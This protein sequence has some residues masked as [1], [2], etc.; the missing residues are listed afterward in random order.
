M[1]KPEPAAVHEVD[2]KKDAHG[3]GRALATIAQ[4]LMTDCVSL[5]ISTPAA[6]SAFVHAVMRSYLGSGPQRIF[7][8]DDFSCCALV[9]EIHRQQSAVPGAA[10]KQEQ[11]GGGS[12]GDAEMLAHAR[13]DRMQA[14]QRLGSQPHLEQLV[15]EHG[16]ALC[17]HFVGVHPARQGR[18][19]GG[20]MLRH[21]CQ[22][23]DAARRHLYLEASTERSQA[24]YARHGFAHIADKPL[25]EPGE[26][27][28]PLL[29]VMVRPPSSAALAADAAKAGA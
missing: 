3:V 19:L 10:G 29:R 7:H 18:G 17:V 26:E 23:A 9:G 15:Q 28:A 5:Y 25:G 8:A 6:A 2:V 12:K 24:L 27:G 16:S 4:S 14:L 11:A 22:L 13:S 21:L 20:A 1:T